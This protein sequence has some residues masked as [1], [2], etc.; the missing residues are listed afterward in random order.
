L[1]RKGERISGLRLAG[2]AAIGAALMLLA[3]GIGAGAAPGQTPSTMSVIDVGGGSPLGIFRGQVTVLSGTTLGANGSSQVGTWRMKCRYL[4]G[5]G[6]GRQNSHFCTFVHTFPNAGSI[7]ASG[8]V[9]YDS[10]MTRWLKVTRATGFYEGSS[11]TVRI[12]NFRNFCSSTPFT[13]FLDR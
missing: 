2:Y 3:A 9:G 5:E 1:R 7:T 11:G 6:R 8:K 12:E 4:G 13:F 10:R